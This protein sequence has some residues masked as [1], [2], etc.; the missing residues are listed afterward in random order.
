MVKLLGED[1][2]EADGNRI[3]L[4]TTGPLDRETT[5]VV[6]FQLTCSIQPAT[7]SWPASSIIVAQNLS[8]AVLDEDDNPPRF[9]E[10]TAVYHVY[11]KDQGIV[12]VR[13]G[14]AF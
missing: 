9:Q 7:E 8:L 2:Q 13:N 10:K 1:G 6:P 14:R 3:E 4:M 12:Q 5:P 11:L